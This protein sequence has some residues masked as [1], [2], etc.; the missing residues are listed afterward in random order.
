MMTRNFF[1]SYL[2]AYSFNLMN[3]DVRDRDRDR[4]CV[5]EF[6]CL[7]VVYS[8]FRKFK[9]KILSWDWKQSHVAKGVSFE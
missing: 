7:R 8:R 9:R 2:C 3:K 6:V 4:E 5:M 1:S